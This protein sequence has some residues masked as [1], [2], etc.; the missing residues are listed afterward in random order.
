MRGDQCSWKE[1]FW[2]LREINTLLRPLHHVDGRCIL[3]PYASISW[4][5]DLSLAKDKFSDY[6]LATS[7]RMENDVLLC[8][9]RMLTLVHECASG[10]IVG[11]VVRV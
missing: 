2:Q 11:G 9:E 5:T 10:S 1:G 7:L 3:I 6:L 8:C 4:L